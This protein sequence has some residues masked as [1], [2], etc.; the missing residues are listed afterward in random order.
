MSFQERIFQQVHLKRSDDQISSQ[1]SGQMVGALLR[2]TTP[3]I[4]R[5][6]GDDLSLV[7]LPGPGRL[8]V[9]Q[10]TMISSA[11]QSFLRSN[12]RVTQKDNDP[13]KDQIR[14]RMSEK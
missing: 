12:V 13:K 11:W 3:T 1:M 4:Y 8:R 6:T 10:W 9:I 7:L 5:Q 2:G 14:Q